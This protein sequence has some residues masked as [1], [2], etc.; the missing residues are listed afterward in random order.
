M[1]RTAF[2]NDPSAIG[3]GNAVVPDLSERMESN[4]DALIERSEVIVVGNS[5]PEVE[6]RIRNSVSNRRV[7]DLTRID[8]SMVSAEGYQGICW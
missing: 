3:R 8:P 6:E 7:V 4:I 1:S 2:R 5:Y